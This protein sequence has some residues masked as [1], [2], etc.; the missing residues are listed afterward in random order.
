MSMIFN[1]DGEVFGSKAYERAFRGALKTVIRRGQIYP[2][3]RSGDNKLTKLQNEKNEMIER[4]L[5]QDRRRQEREV[6][7]LLFGK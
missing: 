4:V 5:H 1:F 7:V 3:R 2:T 6:R